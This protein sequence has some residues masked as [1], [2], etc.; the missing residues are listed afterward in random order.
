MSLLIRLTSRLNVISLFLIV[1]ASLSVLAVFI[2]LGQ[3]AYPSADD[4][5]MASGV[6]DEGFF[7]H[8]W[9]HYFEWS[10]RYSGNALYAAY[11][12]IAGLFDGY[13]LLPAL[14]I[15]LLYL[16]LVG[17]LAAVFNLSLTDKA[18]WLVALGILCTYLLGLRHS[19]SSLYWMAGALTYQS[20]HILLLLCLATIV[21]LRQCQRQ[22]LNCNSWFVLLVVLIVLGT[23]T[24]EINMIVL[25][26]VMA[27]LLLNVLMLRDLPLTGWFLI[28][29][30]TVVCCA[31]VYYSPGNS[32]RESTFPLRHDWQRS[33]EGSFEMGRWSLLVWTGN[34][35]F[36]TA[37]MLTPFAASW[38]YQRSEGLLKISNV[39]LL[40]LMLITF[41]SPIVLQFPAWWAMGGWPPPRSVDAIFF[42]FMTGWMSL[43]VALTI[44]FIPMDW[45]WSKHKQMTAKAS[46]ILFFLT[47]LFVM[48]VAISAKLNAAWQDL[49]LHAAPFYA[50]MMQRHALIEDSR[51]Q[52]VYAVTVPAPAFQL[53]RSIYFNDIRPDWRNVC[54]ASYF[55]LHAIQRQN[56]ATQ[57]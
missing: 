32:V 1:I 33:I 10:G 52:G 39:Q 8:L 11:P 14:L 45:L 55:R 26:A 49:R 3:F 43:L 56:N 24:N 5:C 36:I 7:T 31:V 2:A 47:C 54:Y 40:V 29:T 16:S 9:Q 4:F 17:L 50:Y 35:V 38:L 51:R 28:F 27:M 22:H 53:P 19:A 57:H 37:T 13:A 18:I 21:R 30:L 42:I 6:R 34:P 41:L 15:L 23:G 12:L 48:S 46:G 25:L 20:A 44:R